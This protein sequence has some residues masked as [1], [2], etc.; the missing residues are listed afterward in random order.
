MKVTNLW[1]WA[2]VLCMA[3]LL[4]SCGDDDN[5]EKPKLPL[6]VKTVKEMQ[7][8]DFGTW[9]YFS[10]EKGVVVGTGSTDPKK[11]DDAKWKARTDWDIAFN[12]YNIRT[13]GGVSGN[14]KG[15]VVKIEGTDFAGL[16]KAPADGYV[17]DEAQKLIIAMPPKG[18]QDMPNVGMNPEPKGWVVIT[19]KGPG[20]YTTKITPV[21]LVVKTADGKYVKLHMKNYKNAKG[22]NGYLTFDYVYQKDG[23]TSF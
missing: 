16:A 23:S 7:S 10:F 11:G 14:G 13:N 19:M 8:N 21:L 18:P 2:A 22:K 17:A 15:A 6:N 3:L 5:N 9:H 12:R 4:L 1:K 20:R